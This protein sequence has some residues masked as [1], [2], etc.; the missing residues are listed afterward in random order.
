MLQYTNQKTIHLELPICFTCNAGIREV[1]SIVLRITAAKYQFS[2]HF[3]SWISVQ[4]ERENWL[5]HQ[6]L[7]HYAV[8]NW[9]NTIH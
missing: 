8:E 1:P 6:F 4:I 7:L 9:Q 5:L 3:G 2:A